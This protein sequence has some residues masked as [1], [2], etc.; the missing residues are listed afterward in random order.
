MDHIVEGADLA[1]TADEVMRM[2][3]NVDGNETH[4]T[5]ED[6]T[7]FPLMRPNEKGLIRRAAAWRIKPVGLNRW[8]QS[9]ALWDS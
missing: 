9:A 7:S 4:G 2:R 1:A 5:C 8:I 6:A 3:L